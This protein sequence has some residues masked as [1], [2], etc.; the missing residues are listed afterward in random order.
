MQGS[1]DLRKDILV[2]VVPWFTQFRAVCVSSIWMVDCKD[3]FQQLNLCEFLGVP[4]GV[5]I[6]VLLKYFLYLDLRVRGR[7]RKINNNKT[8]QVFS[9]SA[10]REIYKDSHICNVSNRFHISYL[11]YSISKLYYRNVTG[12]VDSE[13]KRPKRPRNYHKIKPGFDYNISFLIHTIS[14][15]Q[16]NISIFRIIIIND[17]NKSNSEQNKIIFTIKF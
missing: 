10:R 13:I 8:P 1:R 5:L 9:P 14:N 4:C 11:R 15:T 17:N 2:L 6:V 12:R 16:L 7:Y 3:F